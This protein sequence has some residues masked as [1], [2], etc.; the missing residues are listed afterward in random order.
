MAS[1][2]LDGNACSL[3]SQT[4]VS[5]HVAGKKASGALP[6]KR[7]GDKAVEDERVRSRTGDSGRVTMI[8]TKDRKSVV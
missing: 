1:E 4:L 6:A 8:K 2:V 5:E 7:K 3:G